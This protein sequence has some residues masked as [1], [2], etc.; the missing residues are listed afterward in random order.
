M[1]I[2][3]IL[4]QKYYITAIGAY[5]LHQRGYCKSQLAISNKTLSK[6]LWDAKLITL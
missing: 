3:L 6:I 1:F 4:Q 2:S 5:R